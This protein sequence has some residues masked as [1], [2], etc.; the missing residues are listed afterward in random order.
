[1]KNSK[2]QL[3]TVNEIKILMER[4]SKFVSLSGISGIAAGI[5]AFAG[6]LAVSIKFNIGFF[7]QSGGIMLSNSGQG[8]GNS[9]FIIVMAVLVFI[10]ALMLVIIFSYKNAKK[11]NLI[12][13]DSM[14]K[15][16]FINHFIFLLT[17]GIFCLI[18][19]YYGIYF[20]IVGSMLIFYGLALINV[21]K[22]TFNEIAQLGILEICLG[23]FSSFVTVYPLLIWVTGFGLLH[24]IYGIFVYIKYEKG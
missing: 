16:V 5:S 23:F 10:I 12:F 8:T 9:P 11:K 2:E 7:E 19:F 24:I 14:A 3:S 17:G 13:W 1:M 15:R 22:F 4:S 20:L 6:S 18:L 21:S